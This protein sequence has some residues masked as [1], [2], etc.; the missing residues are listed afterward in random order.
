MLHV[1]GSAGPAWQT[2]QM[3]FT[4]RGPEGSQTYGDD[5]RYRFND[6]GMLVIYTADGHEL[7]FSPAAWSVLDDGA[8]GDRMHV[9]SGDRN[10]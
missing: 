6:H 7:T 10:T 9:L 5:E 3:A 8:P 4:L 2:V 1:L